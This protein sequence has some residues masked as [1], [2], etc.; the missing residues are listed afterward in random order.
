MLLPYVE[1]GPLYNAANFSWTCCYVG[2]QA[3]ATNSTIYNT[4]I[5]QLPLPIRWPRG[6]T[7]HQQL[8]RQHRDV[9]H[10]VPHG[11]QHDRDLPG[12]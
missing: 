5:A 11:R 3:D 9:D 12:V 4:R 8:C 7:K 1:Q 6:A 2:P 10:S